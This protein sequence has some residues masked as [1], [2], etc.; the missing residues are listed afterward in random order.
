MN[1]QK[2]DPR[3]SGDVETGTFSLK[4]YVDTLQRYRSTIYGSLVLVSTLF[5]VG[6]L[7]T[8]AMFPTE[9][10]GSLP[11]RLLFEGAAQNQ[12]PNTSP[13]NTAEIVSGPI[14][15]EIFKANDLQQY[16]KYEG[17][18]DALFVRHSSRGPDQLSLSL[19]S[20][21]NFKVPPDALAEKVLADTLAAW[22]VHVERMD[23]LE[24]PSPELS[25]MVLSKER[26]DRQDYLVAAEQLRSTALLLVE[27]FRKLER[28][29]NSR[30]VRTSTGVSLMEAWVNLRDVIQV[31]LEP[32]L[33]VISSEG[34]TRNVR[35]LKLYASA[36]VSRLQLERRA[37]E[38]RKRAI[39][40]AIGEYTTDRVERASS[41]QNSDL[42]YLQ[43]LTDL[44]LKEST[45]VV[46]LDKEL[47][48]YR[49]VLKSV[50][51]SGDRPAGSVAATR[52]VETRSQAAFS[53]IA[54]SA[55]Q[56]TELYDI[57][58]AKSLRP[59]RLYEI[60]G[61]FSRDA[62]PYRSAAFSFMPLL[63]LTFFASLAGCLIHDA[64]RQ[65][66]AA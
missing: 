54:T 65:R 55:N 44:A 51:G 34:V 38:G 39:Q 8:A 4:L 42:E 24:Y 43:R 50:K 14:L 31:E 41:E 21:A 66:A 22:A 28:L 5:L 37:A 57:L 25:S 26:L 47:A 10:V 9:Q 12:Y 36:R 2:A 59:A 17:F 53:V 7:T 6:V 60:T 13:F 35:Q 1:D 23:A 3:P 63:M 56:L 30:I 45:Q 40:T 49:N 64:V 46:R 19:Q 48:F 27:T 20:S 32:L 18:R 15:A 58:S 29:P 16:G 62:G 33:G 11:F 61:P 52:L